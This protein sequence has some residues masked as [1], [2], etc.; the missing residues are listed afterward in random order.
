MW[1]AQDGVW[2][3][4]MVSESATPVI[5]QNVILLSIHGLPDIRL[6]EVLGVKG[7]IWQSFVE[8]VVQFLGPFFSVVYHHVGYIYIILFLQLQEQ[9]IKL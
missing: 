3:R 9:V 6:A 1:V 8:Q 2:K 4:Q 5:D 7:D